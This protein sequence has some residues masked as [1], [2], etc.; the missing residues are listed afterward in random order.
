MSEE[1][2]AE[3][4]GVRIPRKVLALRRRRPAFVRQESWRYKRLDESWRRPRGKDSKMRLQKRGRPPLVKIGYRT[5]RKFRGLH[6]SGFR[7][8][9]ISNIKEIEGL[10]PS[11]HALRLAG[12]LGRKTREKIYE[13]AVEL[14]FKVLNPPRVAEE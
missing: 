14:G 9:L 2:V 5:P 3:R 1:K 13:K 10:D 12:T 6:P 11:I 8:V 4:R 7:E